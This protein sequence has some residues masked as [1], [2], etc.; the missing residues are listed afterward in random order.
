MKFIKSNPYVDVA[1]LMNSCI[2]NFANFCMSHR[3]AVKRIKNRR[4]K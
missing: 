3:A 1:D 2:L 4:K